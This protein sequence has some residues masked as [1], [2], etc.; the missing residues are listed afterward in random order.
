MQTLAGN[1]IH[2]MHILHEKMTCF[3]LPVSEQLPE[4]ELHAIFDVSGISL[5]VLSSLHEYIHTCLHPLN[6]KYYSET[7]LIRAI[8]LYMQ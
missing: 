2:K 4:E 1:L 8:Q 3:H 5:L 7:F 6:F